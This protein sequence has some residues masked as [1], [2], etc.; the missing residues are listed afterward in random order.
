MSFNNSV[1]CHWQPSLNFPSQSCFACWNLGNSGSCRSTPPHHGDEIH[2]Q[3]GWAKVLLQWHPP[4]T[5]PSWVVVDIRPGEENQ[6][7]AQWTNM[8]WVTSLWHRDFPLDI[9]LQVPKSR[10]PSGPSVLCKAEPHPQGLPWQLRFS[11]TDQNCFVVF[12]NHHSGVWLRVFSYI[13]HFRLTSFWPSDGCF[14]VLFEFQTVLHPQKND[15]KELQSQDP[16]CSWPHGWLCGCTL[17]CVNVPHWHFEKTCK[18]LTADSTSQI[19]I[20]VAFQD[21]LLDRRS[22]WL[23]T[24][25]LT[26]PLRFP[27]SMLFQQMPG[28]TVPSANLVATN[29]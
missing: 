18:R 8:I 7:T 13:C 23:W 17:I 29:D 2:V 1:P 14:E 3:W 26:G 5:S 19:R 24:Q 9:P 25:L 27:I 20:K 10:N 22:R 28:D 4:Q 21:R 12:F 11:D 15:L 16:R 6:G